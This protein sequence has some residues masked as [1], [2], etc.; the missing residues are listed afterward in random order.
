MFQAAL[1]S[2]EPNFPPGILQGDPRY[3]NLYFNFSNGNDF[4]GPW[5]EGSSTEM[6]ETYQYID[7]PIKHVLETNGLR[8]QKATG[9]DRTEK[10]VQKLN[11]DMSDIRSGQ[12][13]EASP[14]KDMQWDKKLTEEELQCTTGKTQK[15]ASKSKSKAS[16]PN[17]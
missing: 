2:I 7:D 4:R 8:D 3:S 17:K 10:S 11:R 6:G 12:V 9:T 15:T 14:L 16:K 13:N 1:Q 5:N